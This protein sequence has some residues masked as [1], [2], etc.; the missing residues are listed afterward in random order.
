MLI[1]IP[2]VF[3]IFKLPLFVLV[4]HSTLNQLTVGEILNTEKEKPRPTRSGHQEL[5]NFQNL[6]K[7]LVYFQVSGGGFG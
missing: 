1:S 3:H 6:G 4:I 7:L 2:V 5:E